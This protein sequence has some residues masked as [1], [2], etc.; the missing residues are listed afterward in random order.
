MEARRLTAE[1]LPEVLGWFKAWTGVELTKSL[2]SDYGFVFEVEKHLY[3]ACFAFPVIGA[4]I[5]FLGWPIAN[6]KISKESRS[7]ALDQVMLKAEDFLKQ[8]GYK[9]ITTYSSK[10]SVEARFKKHGYV[11]GDKVV[12]QLI[13]KVG[14]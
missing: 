8:A 12:T 2:L 3:A 4:E 6:P 11:E 7:V 14:G 10:D 9:Y 13:K 5:A 1:E